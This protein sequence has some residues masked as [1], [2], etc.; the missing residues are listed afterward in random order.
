MRSLLCHIE[1][2]HCIQAGLATIPHGHADKVPWRVICVSTPT[3][4]Q[5][6]R[7]PLV[8]VQVRPQNRPEPWV[9]TIIKQISPFG[10]KRLQFH[11]SGE[12]EAAKAASVNPIELTEF[13][14]FGNR[15]RIQNSHPLFSEFEFRIHN[16]LSKKNILL[17]ESLIEGLSRIVEGER[18]GGDDR[19]LLGI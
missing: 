3:P 16:P 17:V 19:L 13:G 4:T 14:N 12:H 5:I 6:Q 7:P 2:E 9:H 10:R 11:P 18:L 15:I 1:K 8:Q